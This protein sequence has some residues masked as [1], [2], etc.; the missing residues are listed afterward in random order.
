M[1]CIV[2]IGEG[3]CEEKIKSFLENR[4]LWEKVCASAE[5][6]R[7]RKEENKYETK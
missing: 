2:H 4:S 1:K 7:Q 5:F 3:E 6:R